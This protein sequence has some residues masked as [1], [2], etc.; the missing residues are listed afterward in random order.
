MNQHNSF[1]ITDRDGWRREFP[2]E[3]AIVYIG[4]DPADDVCLDP[5]HGGGVMPRHLQLIA[6]AS[7]GGLYRMVNLGDAAVYLGAASDRAVQ[8]RSFA[9]LSDGDAIQVGDFH[10]VFRSGDAM[11]TLGPGGRACTLPVSPTGAS[12]TYSATPSGAVLAGPASSGRASAAIGL[13][14]SLPSAQLAPDRPLLGTI[15][16][17]N[18][19]EKPGVQ[20]R[21]EAE[22]LEP[23]CYEIGPGPLL[24]PGAEKAVS[25]LV[26]HSKRPTPPAGIHRLVIRASAPEAYPG[27]SMT[28]TQ[29]LQVLPFLKH[30]LRLELPGQQPDR[31]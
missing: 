12:A 11:L 19:G 10:L 24:F 9:N 2:F 26:R 17:S 8:P 1:E 22:G 15:L 3:K 23:D 6:P 31:Q 14:L 28:V 13:R 29:D 18:L 30:T 27:D 4:N 20:F 16:V 25:L 7:V 5:R 21:L